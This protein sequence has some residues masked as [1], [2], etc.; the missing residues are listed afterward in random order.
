MTNRIRIAARPRPS[1]TPPVTYSNLLGFAM[2][3]AQSAWHAALYQ[4]AARDAQ[5]QV[6]I[7]RLLREMA[8]DWN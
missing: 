4:A 3:P 7:E 1:V 8:A 6:E 2:V 5:L